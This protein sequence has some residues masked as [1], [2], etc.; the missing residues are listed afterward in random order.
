[1]KTANERK[2]QIQAQKELERHN[3]ELDKQIGGSGVIVDFV[4][5][6]ESPPDKVRLLVGDM[7]SSIA[8]AGVKLTKRGNG[9]YLSHK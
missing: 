8:Q 4:A 5:K 6:L 2:A 3:K 1:M 9:L 7:L